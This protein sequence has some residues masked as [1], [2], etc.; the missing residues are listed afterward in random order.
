MC[1]GRMW[2]EERMAAALRYFMRIWSGWSTERL[3][4][5]RIDYVGGVSAMEQISGNDPVTNYLD[6]YYDILDE[7]KREMTAVKPT[8]SISRDFITQMIPHHR[9]AVEMCENMLRYTTSEPVSILARTIIHQQTR[10]IA[11]MK[12]LLCPC[13]TVCN[14]GQHVC[15]YWKRNTQIL[16]TMFSDM[17][18]VSGVGVEQNFLREMIP[19]HEGA[20]RMCENALHYCICQPLRPILRN[21][22]TTQQ[23]EIGEMERLL[24]GMA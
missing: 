6:T 13:G 7:M 23:R 1:W 15:C 3:L 4:P 17:A 12:D 19:H 14:S 16:N 18:H 8:A 5:L 20:V 2:P 22:I 10:G 21:I 9:A 11:K 24:M